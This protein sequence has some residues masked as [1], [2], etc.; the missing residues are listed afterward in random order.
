[1]RLI[2]WRYTLLE[3]TVQAA[4]SATNRISNFIGI[5]QS[6]YSIR[7][8]F[9]YS[10]SSHDLWKCKKN[11]SHGSQFVYHVA[12]WCCAIHQSFPGH[13]FNKK[14]P[15]Y[16]YWDYYYKPEAMVRPFRVY[17]ADSYTSL[18]IWTALSNHA[19]PQLWI[20]SVNRSITW[21]DNEINTI[22]SVYHTT[23]HFQC[24]RHSM[25]HMSPCTLNINSHNDV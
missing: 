6:M 17:N 5:Y 25:T 15:S 4:H 12:V 16:W 14:T 10:R 23:R 21:I 13:P 8:A 2:T 24:I 19:L 18:V 9:S 22:S 3:K 20:K 7:D 11:Y 1:M